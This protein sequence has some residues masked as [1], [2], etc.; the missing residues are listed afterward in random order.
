MLNVVVYNKA[1]A[2]SAPEEGTEVIIQSVLGMLTVYKDH[3]E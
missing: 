2:V 3:I 1:A